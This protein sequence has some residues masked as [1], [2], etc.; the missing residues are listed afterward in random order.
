MLALPKIVSLVISLLKFVNS[1]LIPLSK[2]L[3]IAI[4]DTAI[5]GIFFQGPFCV[6]M[7]VVFQKNA[8]PTLLQLARVRETHHVLEKTYLLLDDVL[9][10][11]TPL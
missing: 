10:S 3:E 4:T 1:G 9:E 8:F 5:D 6:L 2:N 7:G 11:Q